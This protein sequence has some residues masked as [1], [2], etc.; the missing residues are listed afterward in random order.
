MSLNDTASPWDSNAWLAQH[1]DVFAIDA[2]PPF[3][4]SQNA[5]FRVHRSGGDWF[6]KVYTSERNF[7]REV[8]AFNILP[9]GGA[10]S[11][12]H[13]GS[14]GGRPWAAFNWHDDV[15]PLTA[16]SPA[17]IRLLAGAMARIH[18]LPVPEHTA[19]RDRP[20]LW[21]DFQSRTSDLRIENPTFERAV[22][23]TLGGVAT[24]CRE[25]ITRQEAELPKVVLHG[26]VGLRNLFQSRGSYYLGDFERSAIGV[27]YLDF[28][29]LWDQE[30]ARSSLLQVFITAYRS[31]RG[32]KLSPKWPDRRFMWCVRLWAAVGIVPYAQRLGDFTFRQ[33]ADTILTNL[34]AERS[35]LWGNP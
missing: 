22:Q 16:Q 26:D 25:H 35:S 31:T 19:L 18:E 24:S 21:E 14:T 29:K 6:L 1:P 10:P 34:R 30:L 13:F 9:T 8:A 33:L 23:E 32:D 12:V 27:H 3:P 2:L 28:G 4:G 15:R 5:H 7:E 17:N 20:P 11:L